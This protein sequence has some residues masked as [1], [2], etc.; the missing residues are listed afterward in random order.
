[1]RVVKYLRWAWHAWQDIWRF[2]WDECMGP[3]CHKWESKMEIRRRLSRPPG[4]R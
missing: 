3:D 4:D 1:M 2:N